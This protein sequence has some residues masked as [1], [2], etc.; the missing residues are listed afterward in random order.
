MSALGLFPWEKASC[1]KHTPLSAFLAPTS[2]SRRFCYQA[3][4]HSLSL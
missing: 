3:V 1:R 4:I 2:H